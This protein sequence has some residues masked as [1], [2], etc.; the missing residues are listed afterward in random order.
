[1][2]CNCPERRTD[3]LPPCGAFK[4]YKRPGGYYCDCGHDLACHPAGRVIT[5][6][7]APHA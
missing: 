1:M 6:E 5:E 7:E 3:G 2:A 4:G